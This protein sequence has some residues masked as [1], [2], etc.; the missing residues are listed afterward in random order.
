M[1]YKSITVLFALFLTT[2]AYAVPAKPGQI[3]QLTLDNG[4]TVTALRTAQAVEW[5]E[6]KKSLR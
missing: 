1:T 4:T 2:A 3:R 6:I 5:E